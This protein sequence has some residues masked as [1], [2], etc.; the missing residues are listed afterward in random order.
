LPSVSQFPLACKP[1]LPL[2]PSNHV[3]SFEG[4]RDDTE[5]LPISNHLASN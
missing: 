3:Q 2:H 1:V 4:R 5:H